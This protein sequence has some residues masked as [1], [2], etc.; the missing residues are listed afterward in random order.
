MSAYEIFKNLSQFGW[1]AQQSPKMRWVAARYYAGVISIEE[2]KDMDIH[3]VCK[4]YWDGRVFML[5]PILTTEQV[6]TII[7]LR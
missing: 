6:D 4:E 3:R 5:P 7:Y 1:W 2:L